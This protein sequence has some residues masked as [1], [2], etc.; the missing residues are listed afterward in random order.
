MGAGARELA[1]LVGAELG[2]PAPPAA[3]SLAERIRERHG[4]ATAAVVFYGSCLRGGTSA[5]VLDF[6]ALVEF[7]AAT[8]V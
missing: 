3:A 4:A 1:E 2:R 5:G 8:K 6:Y 7:D